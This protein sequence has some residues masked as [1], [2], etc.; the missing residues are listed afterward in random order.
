MFPECHALGDGAL[1]KL[2]AQLQRRMDQLRRSKLA[3][4]LIVL[5]RETL[6]RV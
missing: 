6:R 3:Q 2:G 4:V 5:K 1:E